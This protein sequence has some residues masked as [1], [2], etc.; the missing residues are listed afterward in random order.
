M[1]CNMDACAETGNITDMHVCYATLRR[2]ET[3]SE[4]ILLSQKKVANTQMAGIDTVYHV[5][6]PYATTPVSMYLCT[7]TDSML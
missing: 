2:C 3:L 4:E 1:G 7:D 5:N 6:M